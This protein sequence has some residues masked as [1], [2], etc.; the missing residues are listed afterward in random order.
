MQLVILLYSFE[1]WVSRPVGQKAHA[2]RLSV[3]PP[4]A[5][6]QTLV[7]TRQDWLAAV[8]VTSAA[9]VERGA[10][11]EAAKYYVFKL[12]KLFCRSGIH[13]ITEKCSM[14]EDTCNMAQYGSKVPPADRKLAY[15]GAMKALCGLFWSQGDHTCLSS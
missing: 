5:S 1:A 9:R 13:F 12:K 8:R 10:S 4:N 7:C 15:N 6:P 14:L 2:R 3:W 11:L